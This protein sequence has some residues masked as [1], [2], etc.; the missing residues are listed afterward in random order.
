MCSSWPKSCELPGPPSKTSSRRATTWGSS[1]AEPTAPAWHP[2]GRVSPRRHRAERRRRSDVP[3]RRLR[4]RDL[5]RRRGRAP[6]DVSRRL[7]GVL[8]GGLLLE[9]EADERLVAEDLGVVTRLDH[10]RIA[11][12]R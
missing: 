7:A 11:R 3:G 10:V 5:A 12:A 2:A 1:A 6:R 9:L 4:R 8:L